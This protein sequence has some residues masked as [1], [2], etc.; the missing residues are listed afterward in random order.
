MQTTKYRYPR[1]LAEAAGM[2]T[3]P[4]EEGVEHFPGQ[5][6]QGE[7]TL[8]ALRYPSGMQP[9]YLQRSAASDRQMTGEAPHPWSA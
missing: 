7:A 9:E 3:V 1:H 5:E 8:L 6:S 2:G 4:L